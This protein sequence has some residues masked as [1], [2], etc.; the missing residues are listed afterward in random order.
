[1]DMRTL[2]QSLW[3]HRGLYDT[4]IRAE[5]HGTIISLVVVVD[6]TAFLGNGSLCIISERF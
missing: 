2:A 6:V 4:S 1:M 3:L 5:Y